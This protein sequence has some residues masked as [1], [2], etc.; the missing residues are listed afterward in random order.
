MKTNIREGSRITD[1]Y[2]CKRSPLIAIR[3]DIQEKNHWLLPETLT[4]FSQHLNVPLIEIYSVATFFGACALAPIVAT[5]GKHHGQMTI[6]E[7]EKI[8]DQYQ[9]GK[10]KRKTYKKRKK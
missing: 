7:V 5:D 1:K 6:Q 9:K 4:I 2:H 8:I 10:P 3:Q